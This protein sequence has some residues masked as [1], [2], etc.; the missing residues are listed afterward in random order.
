MA[1]VP[2]PFLLGH[3][4]RTKAFELHDEVVDRIGTTAGVRLSGRSSHAT[5]VDVSMSGLTVKSQLRPYIGED[6]EVD[7][8]DVG[9]LQGMV[10]W[11]KDGCFGIEVPPAD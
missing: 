3:N 9:S 10:S 5:I 8:G 11:W 2:A 4:A 6:V 1:G 7:L